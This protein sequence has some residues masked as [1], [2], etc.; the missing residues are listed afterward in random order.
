MNSQQGD[1]MTPPGSARGP[2][3]VR[4]PVCLGCV[5]FIVAKAPRTNNLNLIVCFA[6]EVA[7]DT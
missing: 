3:W 4:R 2:Q 1:R 6:A 5:I 7:C